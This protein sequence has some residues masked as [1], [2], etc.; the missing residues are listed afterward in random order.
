GAGHR[1]PV[2]SRPADRECG[3]TELTFFEA[4]MVKRRVMFALELIDPGRGVPAG[5]EMKVEAEGYAP[6][7]ITRA[8]QFVWHDIDPPAD[9]Q[10]KVAATA[11]RGWFQPYQATIDVPAR[12]K[13]VAVLVET[14]PL[15]PTGVY[16]PPAGRL[17]AAGMLVD[18]PDPN[19]R[20]PIE[21]A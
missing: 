14:V 10:V 15:E 4:D 21:G 20:H 1:R 16:E 12:K 7:S 17:S 19:A 9:R 18:D 11:V 5:K 2:D 8:G 3:V 13:G 6:P